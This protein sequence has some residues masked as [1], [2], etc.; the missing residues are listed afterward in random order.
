[1][2]RPLGLPPG[3]VRAL[4]LLGLGVRAVFDLRWGH[5]ISA[6]LGTAL[7]LC[8]AAYYSTRSAA[9]ERGEPSPQDPPRRRHPLGLPAG[10]VRLLFLVLAGYGVWLFF[11]KTQGTA[12]HPEMI[13]VLGAFA[14]GVVMRFLLGRARRPP[15][16]GTW[17]VWHLQALAVLLAVTGLV[18]IGAQDKSANVPDWVEPVLAAGAAYY[19]ATR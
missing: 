12:T 17:W 15:D 16:E 3:S 5:G 8:A 14:L 4:L 10:T 6:W 2:L 11:S 13:W 9:A 18:V 7:L 19:F 1:M